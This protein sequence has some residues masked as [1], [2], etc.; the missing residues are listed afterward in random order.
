METILKIPLRIIKEQELVIGPLAWDEARKVSGLTID[1][2][3]DSV[4]FVG[5]G[6]DVINRLVAQYERLFG[7]ASHAVC[8]D[9]VQDLLAEM[10]QEDIPSSLK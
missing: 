4:S 2:T 10:P 1:Q 6:K 3:H 5:D 7:Q 8:H 9:A